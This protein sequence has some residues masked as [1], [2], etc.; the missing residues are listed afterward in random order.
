MLRNY[1][2]KQKYYNEIQGYNS[3]LN[4]LQAAFLRVK[5]HRLDDW[6]RRR[7]AIARIYLDALHGTP[8]LVLPHVPDDVDPVW[9]LFVVRSARRDDLQQKLACAGTGTLIH[10]P[11]PPHL[12]NAYAGAGFVRGSLP[13]AEELAATVLSLPM[14]PHLTTDQAACVA[15]QVRAALELDRRS[16]P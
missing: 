13:I 16:A 8:G 3:R 4:E 9:H 1:G 6:N 5:L 11:V 14:G 10:Y 2:S 7:V 12:S 15:G